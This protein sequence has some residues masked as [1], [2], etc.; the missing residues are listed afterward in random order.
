MI[1]TMRTKRLKEALGDKLFFEI[2]EKYKVR[3]SNIPSA[4][5]LA[6][7]KE[8][9]KKEISLEQ[10]VKKCGYKSAIS[11][12]AMVGRSAENNLLT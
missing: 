6:V 8:F 5:D 4:K 10:A 11:F 1:K 2:M 7:V 3:K 12:Y 9:L